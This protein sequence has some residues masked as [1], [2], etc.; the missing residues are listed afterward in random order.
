MIGVMGSYAYPSADLGEPQ[1]CYLHGYISSELMKQARSSPEKGLPLTI[2][3]TK[4]DGIVLSLTPNSHSYN[5]RSA[6]LFGYGRPVEDHDE[7]IWAMNL[8]TE[9]VIAGRWKETRTPP[10]NAELGS[11][12]ILKVQ[13]VSGSGKIRRG[14]PHDEKKDTERVDVTSRVWTGVVPM[15]EMV[16]EPVPG[17]SGSVNVVPDHITEFREQ[18][19]SANM[20][21]AKEAANS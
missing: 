4:M 18:T 14:L 16:G 1:D 9:S 20:T 21:Y 10:D 3:A 17:G 12:A 15:W 5:Y 2:A 8:V 19:N 13:V 6:I 7:K 11:T